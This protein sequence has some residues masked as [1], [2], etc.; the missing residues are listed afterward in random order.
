MTLNPSFT[1]V[2]GVHIHNYSLQEILE[3]IRSQ[4]KNNTS[5]HT[6]K[7][8]TVKHFRHVLPI[9]TVNPEF[10]VI[11]HEHNRFKDILNR[12]FI[13]VPDGIGILYAGLLKGKRF[14]ERITGIDLVYSCTQLAAEHDFTVG[15]L[16]GRQ[17]AAEK[18]LTLFKNRYPSLNAWSDPGPNIEITLTQNSLNSQKTLTDL[19]KIDQ[20]SY[21]MENLLN[22]ISECNI[23]FVAFGAPKQELFIEWLKTSLRGSM[24]KQSQRDRRAPHVARDDGKRKPI[25]CVG[26]GGS[27]DE[28][29]GISAQSPRWIN[30]VGF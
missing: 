4:L 18:V 6:S 12:A 1:S 15:F 2:L 30:V 10:L 8:F 14:P 9:Y 25:V 28:I 16:G 5:D 20:N 27:L 24:T 21:D 7:Q 23:L 17:D 11:A 26:V 22:K 19:I 13:A 29:S 3:N